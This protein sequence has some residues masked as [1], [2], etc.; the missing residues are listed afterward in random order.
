M[1]LTSLV[2][3]HPKLARV[4]W[5]ITLY[6]RRYTTGGSDEAIGVGSAQYIVAIR[7]GTYSGGEDI[8]SLHY[9]EIGAAPANGV[10]M[11]G[12]RLA[13][14]LCTLIPLQQKRNHPDRSSLG[15]GSSSGASNPSSS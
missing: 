8:A 11:V 4:A 7:S 3:T 13:A 2:T 10:H 6:A 5:V 12:P 1:C 15:G 14:E 9:D